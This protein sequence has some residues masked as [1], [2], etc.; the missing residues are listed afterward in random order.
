MIKS[1]DEFDKIVHESLLKHGFRLVKIG[2]GNFVTC[3]RS[4]KRSLMDSTVYEETKQEVLLRKEESK[5]D[6]KVFNYQAVTCDL[7]REIP[8]QR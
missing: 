2:S 3:P 6:L 1:N 4:F 5:D 8:P 7:C